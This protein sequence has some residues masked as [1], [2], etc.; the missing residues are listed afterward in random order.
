MVGVW[1]GSRA[2]WHCGSSW[3]EACELYV[4]HT[5]VLH[6]GL[7]HPPSVA[8][9]NYRGRTLNLIYLPS[10]CAAA[11]GC[12]WA[13]CG[14]QPP[15]TWRCP[16]PASVRRPLQQQQQPLWMMT[17]QLKPCRMCMPPGEPGADTRWQS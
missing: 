6:G 11:H 9:P 7:L 8:H 15:P 2:V 16:R 14:G 17:P 10:C 12:S 13:S 4:T 3:P 5:C 1:V